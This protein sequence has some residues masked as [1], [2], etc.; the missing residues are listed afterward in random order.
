M[1]TAHCP[2]CGETYLAAATV[3]S[4]CRVAL[5]LDP[6][7]GAGA[8][9]TGEDDAREAD[10]EAALA[11]P[12]GD[13][14]VGYDLEDWGDDDRRELTG[15]L[16]AE[17]V[18]HEW[19]E[20]EVVV[21]ERFAD[22]AEELIDAIDH[23]DALDVD[24]AADD[25]DGGAEALSALYVAT[26]VLSGDPRASGA[27]VELLELAPDLA[28]RSAPYGIEGR[29]WAAVLERSAALAALLEADAGD[30]EVREA[31]VAVR[32]LVRPLV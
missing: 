23:P 26:D 2:L 7:D 16:R 13:D 32:G 14:E 5:V 30:E 11:W 21:P 10:G 18:P 31:A 15:A 25:D 6:P 29:T 8:P 28:G 4:D 20:G 19:R 22:V 12:E 27:I 1:S 3:C 9:A 17:R 24:D